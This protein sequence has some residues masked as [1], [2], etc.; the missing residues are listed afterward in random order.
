M[1]V[2]KKY[3]TN[4]FSPGPELIR[5]TA[6]TEGVSHVVDSSSHLAG[7]RPGAAEGC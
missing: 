2:G 3:T 6:M 1:I 5:G 7:E 4:L